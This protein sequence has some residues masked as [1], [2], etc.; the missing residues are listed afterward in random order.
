MY[1]TVANVYNG[2]QHTQ[3]LPM[4]MTVA[5][6]IVTDIGSWFYSLSIF[7]CKPSRSHLHRFSRSNNFVSGYLN[8]RDP[9]KEYFRRGTLPLSQSFHVC[10]LFNSSR[11]FLPMK[12]QESI[13]SVHFT[14][15]ILCP[16]KT[17][18]K[19]RSFTS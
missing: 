16:F 8:E 12:P 6:T 18:L 11:H 14:Y 7:R 10:T 2:Y 17:N 19:K 5:Q 15:G 9:L 3:L 4:Y 13:I 1:T